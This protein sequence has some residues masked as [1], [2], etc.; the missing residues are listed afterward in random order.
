[1]LTLLGTIFGGLFRLCPELLKWLDKK[2][3]RKHE[4]SMLD[5]QMESDRLRAQMEIQK[6]NAEADV[7]LGQKE[8]EAIIAATN[9]QGKKS[10]VRWID[11]MSSLMRPLI[12]IWWVVFLYTA[13]MGLQFYGLLKFGTSVPTAILTVFGPDEK[14]IAASIISFWF[15]DRS[16]RKS[17]LR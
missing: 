9:A 12:T 4:L 16:L 11:G 6:I 5:K 2:D 13:A 17:S 8:I 3:E 15:V 1:M 14:A 7:L 10:G